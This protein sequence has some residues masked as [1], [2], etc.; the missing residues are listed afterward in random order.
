MSSHIFFHPAN[1]IPRLDNTIFLLLFFT[2]VVMS[3]LHRH[4][5]MNLFCVSYKWPHCN[6]D[7]DHA[8]PDIRRCVGK[9]KQ[10][11]SETPDFLCFFG[12]KCP[13]RQAGRLWLRHTTRAPD[14]SSPGTTVNV[15][16]WRVCQFKIGLNWSSHSGITHPPLVPEMFSPSDDGKTQKEWCFRWP[17]CEIT[18]VTCRHRLVSFHQALFTV[19]VGKKY[20]YRQQT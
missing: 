1:F 18:T 15:C 10:E 13:K 3:D 9:E 6:Y 4:G 14:N 11:E 7:A 5:V 12:V 20:L 19:S 8:A 2:T 17:Q 16:P